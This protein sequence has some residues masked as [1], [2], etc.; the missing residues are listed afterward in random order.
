M[1]LKYKTITFESDEYQDNAS[2][3]EMQFKG[4]ESKRYILYFNTGKPIW[5]Q[6]AN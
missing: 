4:V 2:S 3:N 6:E 5:A 1:W